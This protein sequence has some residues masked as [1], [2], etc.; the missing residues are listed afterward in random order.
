MLK[1]IAGQNLGQSFLTNCCG[2]LSSSKCVTSGASSFDRW[3]LSPQRMVSVASEDCSRSRTSERKSPPVLASEAAGNVASVASSVT[4]ASVDSGLCG[5][6]NLTRFSGG[7]VPRFLSYR[8]NSVDA[9]EE[10]VKDSMRGNSRSFRAF[11]S[12][13][14]PV[15]KETVSGAPQWGPRN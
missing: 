11:R 15:L 10:A 12:S 2:Q 8:G 9:V 14:G 1:L 7:L 6:C 3:L 13:V 5:V 4:A